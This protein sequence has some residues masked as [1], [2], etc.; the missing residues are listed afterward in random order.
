[1]GEQAPYGFDG[2]TDGEF[3]EFHQM[4][5]SEMIPGDDAPWQPDIVNFALT[6]DGYA[7][8]D[9]FDPLAAT[10]NITAEEWQRD[11]AL[12]NDLSIL[13]GCLFFEQRRYRHF[14]SDPPGE[15]M[16]YIRALVSAIRRLAERAS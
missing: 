12:P 3:A 11:G 1:M 4:L 8:F 9:G 10:G 5:T 14:D 6:F 15:S 16:A 13:R 2:P 7:A